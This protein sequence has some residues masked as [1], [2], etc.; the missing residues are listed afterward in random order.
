MRIMSGEAVRFLPIVMNPYNVDEVKGLATEFGSPLLFKGNSGCYIG[1]LWTPLCYPIRGEYDDYGSVDNIPDTTDKDRAELQQF[2]DAFKKY[3]LP[4]GVGENEYHDAAVKDYS[5]AEILN[6]LREGRCFM[7]HKST[8]PQYK[9]RLVPIAWMM[10]KESVWQSLLA[11]DVKKSKEVWAYKD[12][13]FD[14]YSL[15][16]IRQEVTHNI[17]LLKKQH[18]ADQIDPKSATLEDLDELLNL[19]KEMSESFGGL[20]GYRFRFWSQSPL[21]CPPLNENLIDV[22]TECEYMH[23]MLSILRINYAPTTGSGSQ[24]DNYRLWKLVYKSWNKIITDDMEKNRE[25]Y[26]GE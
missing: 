12:D 19:M 3:C 23:T 20:M 16:G 4:I 5:L 6:S 21:S 14:Q 10:I 11:T 9:D 15:E 1:D 22:V 18:L 13:K 24:C 8:L 26:Y 25:M 7:N 17:N 2:L